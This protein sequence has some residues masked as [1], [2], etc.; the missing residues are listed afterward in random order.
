MVLRGY[1][2]NGIAIR[3]PG[4]G[5]AGSLNCCCG[6][7]GGGCAVSF[8][9]VESDGHEMTEYD[10]ADVPDL[11]CV[12]PPTSPVFADLVDCGSIVGGKVWY[13]EDAGTGEQRYFWV[14]YDPLRT[15]CTDTD[16]VY[17]S[18]GCKA[19]AGGN[20]NETDW[21]CSDFVY[22]GGVYSFVGGA[23]T[24]PIDATP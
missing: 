3:T 8:T 16:Y 22:A 17:H 4:G 14:E 24:V 23:D 21:C 19:D 6:Q 13:W 18:W 11:G 15:T 7:G 10:C 2:Y 5:L 12:S 1:S 9:S 20:Y